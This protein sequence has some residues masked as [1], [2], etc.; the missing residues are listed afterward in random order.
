MVGVCDV[1]DVVSC[2]RP[3]LVA[4]A[5]AALLAAGCTHSGPCD[6]SDPES[7]RDGYRCGWTGTEGGTACM[8]ECDPDEGLLCAT[9][10]AC[11]SS[12]AHSP[13][14]FAGGTVGLGGECPSWLDCERGLA[15]NR[16]GR[17][18]HPCAEASPEICIARGLTCDY[19][20]CALRTA[21]G[22][23][24]TDE[25]DCSQY[26]LCAPT[27][28]FTCQDYCWE[29]GCG[30]SRRACDSNDDCLADDAEAMDTCTRTAEGSVGCGMGFVCARTSLGVRRCMFAGCAP[31]EPTC[32]LLQPCLPDPEDPST[33][34]CWTGGHRGMGEACA[35]SYECAPYL[36]C[37]AAGVCSAVCPVNGEPCD[38][39][40]ISGQT[41]R[42]HVCT[43]DPA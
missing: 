19:G 7:C 24:C 4:G 15:C 37:N 30:V 18:E 16:H 39:L 11:L 34:L 13:V 35:D 27:R 20:V 6:R 14:C 33:S 28:L 29:G 10:E 32:A 1:T 9:G 23:P 17:C 25:F 43:P 41:C 5:L 22:A 31:G 42:D 40:P 8:A 3:W 36:A 21:V 2:G 38:R 12:V 26:Q